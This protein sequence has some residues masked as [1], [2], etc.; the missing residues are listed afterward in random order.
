[1]SSRYVRAELHGRPFEYYARTTFAAWKPFG[2]LKQIHGFALVER[3]GA[4]LLKRG[5]VYKRILAQPLLLGSRRRYRRGSSTGHRSACCGERS[6]GI[7]GENGDC[8]GAL[9]GSVQKLSIIGDA[10]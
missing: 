3:T 4:V 5:E 1:M 7:D 8:P 2:V 6:V 10:E 9:V